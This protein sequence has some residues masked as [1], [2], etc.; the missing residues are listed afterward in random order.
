[1]PAAAAIV[2]LLLL[3]VGYGIFSAI[4]G[5]PNNNVGVTSPGTSP[6]TSPKRSPKTSPK[7]TPSP[8]GGALQTVPTYAPAASDPITKVQ[9]CLTAAPCQGATSADTNCTL[10]SS[11]HVDIGIYYNA[12]VGQLTYYVNFFDRC[13]GTTT[14]VFKRTDTPNPTFRIFLPAPNGG[15]PVTIPTAKAAAIVVVAQ[16]GNAMA[17]SAPYDLPGSASSCA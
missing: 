7:V 8:V 1:V 14:Q 11:C 3:G 16:A 17:A 13:T 6:K 2:I 10:N 9:F 12:A 15:F 4:R 5:G